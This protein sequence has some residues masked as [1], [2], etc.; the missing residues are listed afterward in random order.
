MRT[1]VVV[2]DSS[3]VVNDVRTSLAVEPWQITVIDDPRAAAALV[4]ETRPDAVIIDMQ[5][6]SMGGMAIIRDIRATVID[7]PLPRMVLLLDRSADRFLA[8]RALADQA[9]LKPFIGAELRSAL[10]G[11]MARG[12]TPDEE[13]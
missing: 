3:W 4:D 9:V 8:G 11:E 10:H 1:A 12:S 5:V 6:G 7:H 2:T 13:E